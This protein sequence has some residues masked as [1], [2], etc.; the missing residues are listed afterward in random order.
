MLLSLF[1][2]HKLHS[3][4]RISLLGLVAVICASPPAWS[5]MA[6]ENG[7]SWLKASPMERLTLTETITKRAMQQGYF[8]GESLNGIKGYFYLCIDKV[9]KEPSARSQTIARVAVSCTLLFGT[10]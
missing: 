6:S 5:L 8:K 2:A 10:Q 3:S 4:L 1:Y 7:L 9:Y